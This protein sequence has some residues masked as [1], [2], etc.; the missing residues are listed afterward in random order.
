MNSKWEC[1]LDAGGESLNRVVAA[2][3][4]SKEK[5]IA[6]AESCTGGALS[7][8]LTDVPGSSHYFREGIIAYSNE[9][10][11]RLLGVPPEIIRDFGAVSYQVAEEM[12]SRVRK[13][14]AADIGIAITGI[15]GPEGGT[16]EKP[17]GLVYLGLA[18]ASGVICEKHHFAG[19]RK[20]IK[21]HASQAA[22]EL[23]KRTLNA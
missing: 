8:I 23:V 11:V 15:A 16:P 22:L 20:E 1:S 5:T 14:S 19:E 3:L 2:L 10:K 17:V 18:D 9:A 4:T 21:L 6:V 12:A 7:S 13:L